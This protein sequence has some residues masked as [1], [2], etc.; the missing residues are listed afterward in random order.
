MPYIEHHPSPKLTCVLRWSF[1][2]C[3][4]VTWKRSTQRV[5]SFFHFHDVDFLST[6]PWQM[7]HHFLTKISWNPFLN[8][9]CNK[10]STLKPSYWFP[11]T[12]FQQDIQLRHGDFLE[13]PRIRNPWN[14]SE[15]VGIAQLGDLEFVGIGRA[16][17][18]K[19]RT[20]HLGS[21]C[22]QCM[23][24]IYLHESSKFLWFSCR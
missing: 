14:Q 13:K 23:V 7:S 6:I 11:F 17:W 10:K 5:T 18:K 19:P 24:Y 1:P 12:N 22:E 20:G 2:R 16:P 21:Q 8:I 9:P 3:K 15:D 4:M